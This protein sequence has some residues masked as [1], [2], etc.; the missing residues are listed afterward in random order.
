ML[1]SLINNPSH[2]LQ[3]ILSLLIAFSFHEASHAWLAYKLGDSTAKYEGRLT[4]NPLAHI[5]LYGAVFLLLAGIGWGKPVPVNPHNFANPLRD[6]LKVALAGPI[7][8]FLLAILAAVLIKILVIFPGPFVAFLVQFLILFISI[9]LA[10]GVFNLFPIPPLDGSKILGLIFGM[11]IYYHLERFGPFILL[12]FLL[13]GYN[14]IG[15]LILSIT[16]FFFRILL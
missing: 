2:L 9:N 12:G 5:D 3:F 1:F 14:F 15:G 13:V 10:L 6:N 8:N 4:L 11:N 7:T 16:S